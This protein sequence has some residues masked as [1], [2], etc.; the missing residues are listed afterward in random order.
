VH[1]DWKLPFREI[2]SGTGRRLR[3]GDDLAIVTIGIAGIMA[4][5]AIDRLEKE[6]FSIAHYDMRF[7][8]PLDEDLLLEIFSR[9][10]KIITVE[11]GSVAGGLGSALLE[12]MADHHYQTEIKRL[13]IP[14]R[15]IDHGSQ[16]ELYH[17]CGFD[18]EGIVREVKKLIGAKKTL[19]GHIKTLHPIS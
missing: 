16:E 8:K 18:E 14:D 1:L 7:L 11:D 2:K 3:N 9:H 13:G 4:S 17:E 10:R 15:F 6:N 5:N 19:S 12:Y